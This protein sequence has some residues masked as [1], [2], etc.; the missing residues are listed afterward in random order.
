[1]ATQLGAQI[2]RPYHTLNWLFLWSLTADAAQRSAHLPLARGCAASANAAF[3]DSPEAWNATMVAEAAL[4]AALLSQALDASGAAGVA[5]VDDLA[6]GYEDCL[7]GALITPKEHEAV[8]RQIALMSL[9]YLAHEK[10]AGIQG[11]SA[12]ARLQALAQ[13]LTPSGAW[14]PPESDATKLAA[15]PVK[16]ARPRAAKSTAPVA[17]KAAPRRRK[18]R[19]AVG[20]F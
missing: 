2:V 20:P 9:F 7:H 18:T 3:V 16:A 13:R 12:G 4:V 15:A 17:L 10:A 5:A 8:L 19:A 11:P 6:R 1:M 14:T